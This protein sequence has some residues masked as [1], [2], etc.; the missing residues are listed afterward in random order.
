MCE[1]GCVYVCACVSAR[2]CGCVRGI[3]FSCYI[4]NLWSTCSTLTHKAVYTP[5]SDLHSLSLSLS[6][7]TD[8]VNLV[9]RHLSPGP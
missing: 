3:V 6:H 2:V 8:D 4:K 9:W 1:F 5:C 7:I